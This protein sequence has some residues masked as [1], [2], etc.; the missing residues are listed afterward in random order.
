MMTSPLYPIFLMFKFVNCMGL[1]GFD[2]ACGVYGIDTFEVVVLNSHPGYGEFSSWMCVT[3]ARSPCDRY[4]AD[5]GYE[6]FLYA[7][8]VDIRRLLMFLVEKLPRTG[9]G[10][11]GGGGVDQTSRSSLLC[12]IGREFKRQLSLPW[13]PAPLQAPNG[14]VWDGPTTFHTVS[15]FTSFSSTPLSLSGGEVLA[16]Q[17]S[18]D[19]LLCSLVALNSKLSRDLDITNISSTAVT[20]LSPEK[21][22]KIWELVSKAAEEAAVSTITPSSPVGLGGI[23]LSAASPIA[24]D[25][26][27][28]SEERGEEKEDEKTEEE[29]LEDQR[30]ETAELEEV[31]EGLVEKEREM[32]GKIEGAGEKLK[33]LEEGC[34]GK[35]VE[36]EALG[37]EYQV[38]KKTLQLVPTEE[39]PV[40]SMRGKL[41]TVQKESQH[42]QV[43]CHFHFPS[44]EYS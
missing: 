25:V 7:N 11:G 29:L 23:R 15:K 21:R 30:T 10:G 43:I 18:P 42:I 37:A 28:K 4:K 31:L 2:R 35:E 6:T 5:I 44:S 27:L 17:C 13:L 33:G 14:V 40:I 24:A 12:S 1:A 26:P 9:G 16:K 38:K 34:K 3:N 32:R 22:G 36:L 19:Q 20:A 8:E 41:E 39:S